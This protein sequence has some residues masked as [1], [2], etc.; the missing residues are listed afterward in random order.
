MSDFELD[1]PT[2]IITGAVEFKTTP[3]EPEATPEVEAA[4]E[5]EEPYVA[6]ELEIHSP[7]TPPQYSEDA[8][9][10]YYEEPQAYT[11]PAIQFADPVASGPTAEESFVPLVEYAFSEQPE[12]E[13]ENALEDRYQPRPENFRVI[14]QIYADQLSL[15]RRTMT[16]INFIFDMFQ[17]LEEPIDFDFSNDSLRTLKIGDKLLEVQTYVVDLLVMSGLGQSIVVEEFQDYAKQLA[18]LY[19]TFDFLERYTDSAVKHDTLDELRLEWEE[20]SNFTRVQQFYRIATYSVSEA[21]SYCTVEI[22]ALPE[23]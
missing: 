4:A 8:A 16:A 23:F 9:Q 17:N 12:E 22:S 14:S 3:E 11:D 5:T 19:G 7:L 10:P 13:P 21:A 6:E 18:A 1:N 2:D 15:I 20:G